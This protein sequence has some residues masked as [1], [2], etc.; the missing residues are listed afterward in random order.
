MALRY[1]QL[2]ATKARDERFAWSDRDT[3]L[4]ALAVGA[5]ANTD[6]PRELAFA[7]EALGPK[8]VPT[9]ANTLAFSEFLKGCGWNHG[10]IMHAG[11]RLVIRRPLRP[12]GVILLDSEVVSAHDRGPE[13]GAVIVTESRARDAR[14]GQPLFAL[15]R[16]IIARGDGGFGG[17]PGQGP[18]GHEI[19]TRRADLSAPCAT[20]PDQALLY[21]L[22]GDR[23]ALHADPEVARGIGL[24]GPI[25]HGLCTFGIACVAL[26]RTIC[27]FD[28]LLI[29]EF[30]ARFTGPVFPGDPLLV[31]MWQDGAVVSFRVTA[32]ARGKVVVDGGRCLLA[33]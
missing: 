26:L 25:L 30:E 19:P 28:P 15:T 3:M 29:R 5:I 27:E 7:Y 22:C 10:R 6:D 21:R 16:T 14:D 2:M 13:S 9:F 32:T 31:E 8:V 18:R 4:Y 24:S 17:P 33:T 23:N 1:E 11:E 20:R 12:S